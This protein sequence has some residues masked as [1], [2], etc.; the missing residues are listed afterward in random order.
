MKA[1]EKIYI[2]ISDY[3]ALSCGFCPSSERKSHRGV[4]PLAL[5]E[6]ICAQIQNDVKRVCLHVLGDPLSVANFE[7]YVKI[8]EHYHLKVDLVTTG[9]FLKQRHFGLLMQ[10][11]FVQ[12]SFSLS[13]FLA[14]PASLHNAHLY[15]ILEFCKFHMRYKSSP[16]INLRFHQNDIAKDG[17]LYKEMMATIGAFFDIEPAFLLANL[18]HK[19]IRLA[20]KIILKPMPSFEWESTNPKQESIKDKGE[21]SGF[22]DNK[23][24]RI[25][26]Y[27]ALK[28]YGILSNGEL[29]PCCIDYAGRASFGNVGEQSIREILQSVAFRE[30]GAQLKRGLAPCEL[31]EKCGY[32]M[33]L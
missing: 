2:E 4:M 16:F 5:F 6:S 9:L 20:P 3:C 24:E 7:D 31:C 22:K 19:R 18:K 26:C 29:V 10:K 15:R 23:S 30:F 33:I 32:R 25:F 8:L 13:A 11:P 27:G 21:L 17:T 1:F 14:N 12:I 28:Q